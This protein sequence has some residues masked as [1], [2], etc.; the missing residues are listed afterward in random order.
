MRMFSRPY[1]LKKVWLVVLQNLYLSE[2]NSTIV[3][4]EFL[5]FHSMSHIGDVVN[6]IQFCRVTKC[7]V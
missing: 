3:D 6:M 5:Q 4:E 1:V 7:K 2:G